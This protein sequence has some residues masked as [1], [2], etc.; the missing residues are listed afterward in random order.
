MSDDIDPS[1]V[2]GSLELNKPK[3]D[4]S[5]IIKIIL[6]I[7]MGGLSMWWAVRVLNS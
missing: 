6:F 1:A 3:K 4:Y 5:G 7:G 2:R